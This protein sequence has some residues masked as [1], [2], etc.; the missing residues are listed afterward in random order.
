MGF[1]D[2]EL[3]N[4][5]L[6][7]KH[8]WRFMVQPDSLCARVLKGKYF[9]DTDF[10]QA[11]VPRNSSA[12]WRAIVAGREA[13]NLGLIKRIGDGRSVSVWH[14]NWIPGTRTRKPSVQISTQPGEEELNMVSDLIDHDIGCWKIEKGQE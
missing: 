1:R 6:L 2:L 4:L 11:T 14:D 12:T 10:L 9:P 3:F 7:G 8:G 13:L 5:A